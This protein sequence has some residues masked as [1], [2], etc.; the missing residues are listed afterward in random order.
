M[1]LNKIQKIPERAVVRVSPSRAPSTR[2]S[3]SRDKN[4]GVKSTS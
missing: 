1:F 4:I 2:H 3:G